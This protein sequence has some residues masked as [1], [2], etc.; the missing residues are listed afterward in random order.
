MARRGGRDEGSSDHPLYRRVGSRVPRLARRMV[1]T[2]VEEIPLYAVLPRE[3]LHGE[4]L[5]ITE[6]NLRLFFSALREGRPLTDEELGDIRTSA[7]RRA[8]ERVPLDAVLT[9]YHVGGRIGWP[10][11]VEG[12]QP[13]ETD[14]VV[15]AGARVLHYVQ[16][17]TA[18]VSAAYL[19]EQQTIYGEER[20]ARRSLASALLS[21]EPVDSLAARL[22]A[23]I[24]P[25]YLVVAIRI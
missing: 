15:A 7:A 19:E 14:A 6:A 10:A 1:E 2:F 9:A 18:A 4:I 21:G 8:E 3:Q 13:D 22:G 23:Q 16:Q 25:A 24:A 12:A 11:I 5:D 17:V 20:D